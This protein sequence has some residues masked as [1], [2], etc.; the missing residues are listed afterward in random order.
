MAPRRRSDEER[1]S[2]V[3]SLFRVRAVE[4][5]ADTSGEKEVWHQGSKGADLFTVVNRT[6]H[7]VRQEFILYED[8]FSWTK[9]GGLR[10]GACTASRGIKDVVKSSD[11]IQ[12]DGVVNDDRIERARAALNNY[13]GNDRYLLHVRAVINLAAAGEEAGELSA[14]TTSQ[15]P[16]NAAKI[17]AAAAESAQKRQAAA[18]PVWPYL[19]V[20]AAVGFIVVAAVWLMIK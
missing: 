14:V 19:L 11:D 1:K 20:G 3:E 15:S 7:V 10:T 18:N 16:Q 5:P 9:Q 4:T 8:Y 2:A 12:L 17:R 13:S 6:G